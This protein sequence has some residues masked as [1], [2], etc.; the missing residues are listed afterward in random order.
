MKKQLDNIHEETLS[1]LVCAEEYA[2]DLYGIGARW[3][4]PVRYD[5]TLERELRS[6]LA[7]ALHEHDEARNE[8]VHQAVME[9]KE[10]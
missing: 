4:Q 8:V 1:G 3:N 10:L 2:A 6:A 7:E 9:L 5:S